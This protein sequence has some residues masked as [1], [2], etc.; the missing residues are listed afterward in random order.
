MQSPFITIWMYLDETDDPKLRADLALII[1]EMLKQRI[2]GIKNEFGAWISP[3]FPK[4]VMCIS[5]SNCDE[6]TPYWYLTELA[7][8]CTAKRMVPDYVSEKI[9][10]QYKIDKNGNGNVYPPMGLGIYSPCKIWLT[11]LKGCELIAC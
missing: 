2:K 9:M 3:A 4:L 6:S 7:A 5:R 10:L 8:K 11:L 1:E